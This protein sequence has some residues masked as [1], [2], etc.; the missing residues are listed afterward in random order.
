MYFHAAI[1]KWYDNKKP[2]EIISGLL[3]VK[4]IYLLFPWPRLA[5]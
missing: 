2:A 5:K 3:I 1:Y 4:I